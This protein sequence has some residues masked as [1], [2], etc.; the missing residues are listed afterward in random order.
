MSLRLS[1]Y[2]KQTRPDQTPKY[3]VNM[4]QYVVVLESGVQVLLYAYTYIWQLQLCWDIRNTN[5]A[6]VS[7]KKQVSA[8]TWS[9]IAFW[10]RP[11]CSR[12][13]SCT[14]DSREAWTWS[15]RNSWQRQNLSCSVRSQDMY[16]NIYIYI[17]S[18]TSRARLIH[19]NLT[20]VGNGP[21]IR[22]SGLTGNTYPNHKTLQFFS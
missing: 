18:Q 11:I 8:S 6:T 20:T 3:P 13:W 4:S 1:E 2:Q 16:I 17:I 10:T 9:W 5:L 7:N 12:M 22:T 14:F 15:G 19:V 21:C